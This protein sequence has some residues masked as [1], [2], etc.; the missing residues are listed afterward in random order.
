MLP[1]LASRLQVANPPADLAV[2]RVAGGVPEPSRLLVVERDQSRDPP[3]PALAQV[4]LARS[5]KRQ[6]DPLASTPLVHRKP[7]HVAP[8]TVP[9]RDQRPDDLLIPFG[10][11][12]CG[13]RALRDQPL[14]VLDPVLRARMPAAGLCPQ[15]QDSLHIASPRS[16]QNQLPALQVSS[17]APARSE[18]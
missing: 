2:A 11:Q 17:I 1:R 4:V 12:Q 5:R 8:P 14:D 3:H 10:H 13:G 7:I 9:A 15:I 6:S 16:A 18:T